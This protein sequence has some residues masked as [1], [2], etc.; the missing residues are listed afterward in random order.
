MRKNTNKQPGKWITW[1]SFPR[2]GATLSL[3]FPALLTAYWQ[4]GYLSERG[5]KRTRVASLN[6]DRYLI[7]SHDLAQLAAECFSPV[8]PVHPA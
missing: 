2:L 7:S 3:L 5:H 8:C 6:H 4:R 1:L